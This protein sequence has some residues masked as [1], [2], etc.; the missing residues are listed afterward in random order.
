MSKSD[1]QLKQDII[2]ELKL[3]PQVNAAQIGVSVS[4]GAVT[5]LV[6]RLA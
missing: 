1:I 4:D 2:D 6:F 5:L 3:D